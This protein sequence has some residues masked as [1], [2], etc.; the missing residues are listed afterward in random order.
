MGDNIKLP[1]GENSIL[2]VALYWDITQTQKLGLGFHGVLY[3]NMAFSLCLYYCFRV[4]CYSQTQIE[5]FSPVSCEARILQVY[6]IMHGW[7]HYRVTTSTTFHLMMLYRMP[8]SWTMW[9]L[10]YYLMGASVEWYWKVT[11]LR[12][13]QI[14][15]YPTPSMTNFLCNRMQYSSAVSCL[16]WTLKWAGSK[17]T[18]ESY[19]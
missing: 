5:I 3:L 11:L 16:L 13:S 14:A 1:S 18:C 15:S 6:N 8:G 2:R 9:D 17:I 7:T 12:A 4:F 19:D 10:L